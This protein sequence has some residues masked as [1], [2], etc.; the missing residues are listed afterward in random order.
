M[1]INVC[2]IARVKTP[3]ERVWALLSNPAQYSKWWDAATR[4][5]QPEG[6]IQTGQVILATSRAFGRLWDVQFQVLAV[7]EIHHTL[8]LHT[9]L[10]IGI[11]LHNH[12]A[13]TPI[14]LQSCQVS[15]G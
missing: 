15:F 9:D 10:P 8:D 5:I 1:P 2:P 11:S 13:C 12:I 4:S 3:V 6:R 7:D 14:D